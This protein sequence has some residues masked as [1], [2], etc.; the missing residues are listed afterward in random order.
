M[1]HSRLKTVSDEQPLSPVLPAGSLQAVG[2]LVQ[3]RAFAG[4][5]VPGA[6]CLRLVRLP[7]CEGLAVHA[8]HNAGGCLGSS[9]SK[10]K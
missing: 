8:D 10:E 7:A 5:S 3:I 2:R 9:P 4:A 1:S 6:V